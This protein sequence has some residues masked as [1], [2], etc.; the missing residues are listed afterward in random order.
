MISAGICDTSPS[1]IV[2]MEYVSTDSLNDSPLLTPRMMPP[3]QINRR[4]DQTGDGIA[5]HKFVGSI[6]R[7]VKLSSVPVPVLRDVFGP[8]P[9]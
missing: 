3:Q 5:T 4:N 7:P 9:H 2:R 6:H 8:V 1:P